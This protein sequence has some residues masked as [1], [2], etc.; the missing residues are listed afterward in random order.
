MEPGSTADRVYREAGAA[1]AV[2]ASRYEASLMTSD[3]DERQAAKAELER[4]G[5]AYA[6]AMAD[7]A[8]SG[9]DLEDASRARRAALDA[10]LAEPWKQLD[11]KARILA[12]IL[13]YELAQ[14]DRAIPW[15]VSPNQIKT[16]VVYESA[17]GVKAFL[18]ATRT[19][20]GPYA[21]AA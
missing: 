10:A 20:T 16:S 7:V 1:Y 4:T 3:L 8:V 14:A 15:G 2:A 9:G 12:S 19:R 6:L 17:N 18:S 5:N 21:T 11:P 13:E